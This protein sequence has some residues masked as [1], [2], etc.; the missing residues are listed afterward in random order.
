MRKR[1]QFR[2]GQKMEIGFDLIKNYTGGKGSGA[3]TTSQGEM[4]SNY[5]SNSENPI[6][7]TQSPTNKK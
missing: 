3:M 1:T 6:L 4:A 7:T 5:F 2:Q